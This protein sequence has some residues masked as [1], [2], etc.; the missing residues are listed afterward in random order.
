MKTQRLA[1]ELQ[2]AAL[3]FAAHVDGVDAR[4]MLACGKRR[5]VEDEA[6]PLICRASGGLH[7]RPREISRAIA[8][9]TPVNVELH[10]DA[11]LRLSS[12]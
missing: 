8:R 10:F 11:R 2:R 12:D 5:S 1:H 3:A 6:V 4:F 7:I 9:E